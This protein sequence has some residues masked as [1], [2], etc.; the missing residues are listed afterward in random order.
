VKTR[1]IIVDGVKDHIIPCIS[2]KKTAKDMWKA[3]MK[4]Y[5]SDNQSR[6]ML[7][8]EKLR[9]TKMAKRELVVTYL[10]KFT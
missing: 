1:R 8:R 2:R 5:Q 10:T 6:K 3:L 9:S 7:L 4:L